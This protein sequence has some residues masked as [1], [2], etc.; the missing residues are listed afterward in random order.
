MVFHQRVTAHHYP[1][2]VDAFLDQ[3]QK[4]ASIPIL[5]EFGFPFIA[6]GRAMI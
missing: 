4:R 3:V 6:P 1:A 2:A 5:P